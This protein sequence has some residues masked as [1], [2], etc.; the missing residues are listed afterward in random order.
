MVIFCFNLL[1]KA[2]WACFC[3]NLVI[4]GLFFRI[5]YHVF[6]FNYFLIFRFVTFS[7]QRLLGLFFSQITYFWLVFHIFLLVFAKY[8]DL[9]ALSTVAVCLTSCWFGIT[10]HIQHIIQ[11]EVSARLW[12]ARTY[13]YK[14]YTSGNIQIAW[15]LV[16]FSALSSSLCKAFRNAK[17]NRRGG[18]SS[19]CLPCRY[20]TATLSDQ[21]LNGH[22]AAYSIC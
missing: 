19:R 22:S 10:L 11:H 1:Q 12:N 15:R 21:S 6:L 5:C 14:Y 8:P 18:T 4:L 9:T 3:E 13:V 17:A 2:H 16:A 20:I 7:S